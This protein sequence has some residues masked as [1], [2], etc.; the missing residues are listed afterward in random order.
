MKDQS[1]NT[2][3][4][5]LKRGWKQMDKSDALFYLFAMFIVMI[6]PIVAVGWYLGYLWYELYVKELDDKYFKDLYKKN[7]KEV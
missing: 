7:R 1:A 5:H 4:A 6:C 3:L 2:L